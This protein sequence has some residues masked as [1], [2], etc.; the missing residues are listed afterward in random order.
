ME[1]FR[2]EA[3]GIKFAFK[4]QKKDVGAAWRLTAKL[5]RIAESSESQLLRVRLALKI[6]DV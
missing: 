1:A 3:T 6:G 4:A 2:E 5:E